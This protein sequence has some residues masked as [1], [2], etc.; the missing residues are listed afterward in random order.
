M[1]SAGAASKTKKKKCTYDPR[2]DDLLSIFPKRG[3][4][5]TDED[6]TSALSAFKKW[7]SVMIKSPIFNSMTS[8][9]AVGNEMFG[10]RMLDGL[11]GCFDGWL[12]VDHV[13]DAIL[14][15]KCAGSRTFENPE[16]TITIKKRIASEAEVQLIVTVAAQGRSSLEFGIS[17]LLAHWNFFRLTINIFSND[18]W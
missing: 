13:L 5:L 3:T 18:D 1:A 11:S 14:C 2:E 4:S 16:C 6:V 15:Y 7:S 8:A 17:C 9:T 12:P 10:F